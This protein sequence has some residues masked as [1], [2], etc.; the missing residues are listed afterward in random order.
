MS[1]DFKEEYPKLRFLT[2]NSVYYPQ[3]N[4]VLGCI[5]WQISS[6]VTVAIFGF[7]V[8]FGNLTKMNTTDYGQF[9]FLYCCRF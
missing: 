9:W 3:W 6:A 2:A 1:R 5:S 4:C 8:G 7:A